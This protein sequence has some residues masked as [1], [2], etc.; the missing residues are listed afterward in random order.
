M[1]SESPDPIDALLANL[2]ATA[3]TF[4]EESL[5]EEGN[6]EDVNYWLFLF[7]RCLIITAR[8]ASDMAQVKAPENVRPRL[9]EAMK[10]AMATLLVD[11]KK[12]HEHTVNSLMF[13]GDDDD[14]YRLSL[15]RVDRLPV[16]QEEIEEIAKKI[17][18]I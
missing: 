15:T 3:H 11:H 14:L 2:K 6:P 16:S 17:H 13:I 1:V 5:D 8:G 12:H 9:A 4:I 10:V 18:A 7:L